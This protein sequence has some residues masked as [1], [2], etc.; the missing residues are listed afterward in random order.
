MPKASMTDREKRIAQKIREVRLHDGWYL[1]E[2]GDILGVSWQMMRRYERGECR[3]SLE[4]LR[5]L[6]E[7][8]ELPVG[9]F[10]DD[11]PFD[12]GPQKPIS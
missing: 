12:L 5:V 9:W 11:E 3:I 4:K 10:W 8:L 1:R 6:A 7:F 2:L